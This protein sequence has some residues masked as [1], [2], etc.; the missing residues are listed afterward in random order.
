MTSERIRR[1]LSE[2]PWATAWPLLRRALVCLLVAGVLGAPLAVGWAVSHTSVR[3][4]V[5]ITPTTFSLSLSGRSELRLG[6]AGTVYL[7]L[8][9]GPVG[10]VVSV[11]GPG[12]PQAGG[13]DLASYVTPRML[14][15]Y[16]SLFH[17]AGPAVQGYVDRLA[18]ELVRQLLVAELVLAG[19]GGAALLALVSLMPGMRDPGWRRSR[20]RTTGAAAVAMLATSTLGVLQVVQVHGRAPVAAAAYPLPVL[21]GTVAAGSTTNSPL[22]RVLLGGA[23]PKVQALVRRQE[24]QVRAYQQDAA[25][26]LEDQT[27]LMTGPRAGEAAVLM[28]SDMHCNT[29]LIRLQKQVA[30]L[31]RERFGPDVPALM[32]ITGD[33]TTNGTAA[34]G[35]CI[36][37]EAAIAGDAPV[38]A[39]TGN[40]ESD[41]SVSQ[42]K[43][44]GM[45]VLE[46]SSAEVGGVRVLGD[47][48]PNRSE[49][50]G[51]TRLRG[52]ETQA[53]MGARLH[54][55]A[56][57]QPPGLLLVHE[58]YAAQ[59]FIG[60]E[61]MT[62]FLDGRGSATEPYDDG[63]RD[64]PAAAVFYGHWHR[65][66]EPRVVW[67]SDGTWTLV[68]ELDTSGGAIDTP[69]IT[70]FS[71]PWSPPQQEASF[72]VVFLDRDS[73]LVTGYQLYRFATD[74]SVTVLP[75]VDVGDLAAL[76]ASRSPAAR[77]GGTSPASSPSP[78]PSA[79]ASTRP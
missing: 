79:G 16:T 36:R 50:F 70:H 33:L 32:G 71:T 60:V 15:L 9:R 17:D 56:G 29:S 59:A 11:D 64:L 49:L 43:D 52:T 24:S 20:A 55:V 65:A 7:P 21:D 2:R 30:D 1:R 45:T 67:N 47:R 61:G 6:I 53:E 38:A 25:R 10:V 69:T 23:V 18:D 73:G 22:L 74:G 4:T 46:G 39:V 26:G 14:Q 62:D 13:G 42:M 31:L 34:E 78:S 19:V 40:H 41:V 77:A 76:A 72:P 35:G 63:V 68:M 8:S 66:I 54:D 5:G 44:A 58:A 12:D 3:E 75:R 48:D 28:Q 57:E 37:R 51:A 27:V